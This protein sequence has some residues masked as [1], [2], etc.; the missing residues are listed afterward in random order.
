MQLKQFYNIATEVSS[1]KK[2][3]YFWWSTWLISHRLPLSETHSNDT[4]RVFNIPLALIWSKQTQL[5]PF[6]IPVSLEKNQRCGV[7][8]K[9][10]YHAAMISKRYHPPTPQADAVNYAAVDIYRAKNHKLRSK[11]KWCA[12]YRRN[13]CCCGIHAKL[14]TS[15]Q[16]KSDLFGP[17]AS[18][19]EYFGLKH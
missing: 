9:A 10:H 2:C 15:W 6:Y 13:T 18:N 3:Y 5:N 1:R 7:S 19:P 16:Q 8:H 12:L 11:L 17:F 4:S 14:N